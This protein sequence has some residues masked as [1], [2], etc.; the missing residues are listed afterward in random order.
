MNR[1]VGEVVKCNVHNNVS[2]KWI[3]IARILYFDMF[4]F[5]AI[6][7]EKHCRE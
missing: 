7:A 5:L 6:L 4:L 3:F 2:E 1:F